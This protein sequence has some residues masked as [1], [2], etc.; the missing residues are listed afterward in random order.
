MLGELATESGAAPGQERI[1][2]AFADQ[3]WLLDAGLRPRQRQTRAPE[4]F[5]TLSSRQVCVTLALRRNHLRN[6]ASI[7][8]GIMT[9]RRRLP[10]ILFLKDGRKVATLAQ[11]RDALLLL[12]VS[13]QL[14]PLWQNAAELLVQT[15]YRNRHAPISDIGSRLSQVFS[16]NG[17]I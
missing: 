12:P 7:G 6:C 10:I 9:W 4:C 11:A 16:A 13:R 14:D 15:A 17:L 2:I 8:I 5:P 1:S 3:T